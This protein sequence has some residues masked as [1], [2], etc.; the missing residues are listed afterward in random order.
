MLAYPRSI[1]KT[2]LFLK[3]IPLVCVCVGGGGSVAK[4]GSRGFGMLNC[5]H[6]YTVLLVAAK[7]QVHHPDTTQW[8][9]HVDEQWLG[10]KSLV[11][12]EASEHLGVSWLT[13]SPVIADI[14]H[15]GTRL[16]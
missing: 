6:H 3:F 16:V 2:I 8:H 4:H 7:G 13:S 12:V 14:H 10:V 15:G 9:G 11:L 5:G 1:A